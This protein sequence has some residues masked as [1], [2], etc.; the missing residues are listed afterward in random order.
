MKQTF[1][2]CQKLRELFIVMAPIFVSQL[3]VSSTG[4]FNTVMAGHVS[5]QDLAGVATGANLFFMFFIAIMGVIS[6]LTPTISQL[7]GAG[8]REKIPHIVKQAFYW[9]IAISAIFIAAGWLIV[10]FLPD[11]L[12]L[13][14]KVGYVM[15]RYLIAISCGVVQVF[16]AAVLR[17]LI[18]AHGL[19]RLTM[20]ITLITVP[21]NI[22]LNYLFMYGA[23]GFPRLGG[24]G[25][26]VGAAI[27]WTLSLI[28]N[29]FVVTHIDETKHYHVFENFP[30]PDFREWKKQLSLGIPIGATMFCETSIFGVVGLLMTAYGTTIMAAHQAAFNYASV[31]YIIPLSVSMG[32]TII[33][34]YEIGARRP[35]DAWQYS[36]IGRV[37]SIAFAAL[38]GIVLT[39]NRDAITA[40]YTDSETVKDYLMVFLVYA[41]C[42]QGADC[43]NAPLQGTLRGAKDVHVTFLLAVLSD[44][45]IG[46]P[47]GL[48]LAHLTSF[49]QYGY[50]VGLIVGL[51]VGAISLML[52]LRIVERKFKEM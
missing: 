2:Y 34:G 7:Y 16:L 25:A 32:L 11:F 28:I 36:K 27:T 15:T 24:I 52:R 30:R 5:E 4:F 1:S 23:L 45:I 37:L 10:P 47:A 35:E 12:S 29:A 43:I 38:V 18:D 22:F 20:C 13:E 51:L 33:V 6:G 31:V 14:P 50:W 8:K 39:M 46:L 49:A 40:I 9:S 41:T 44:W 48:A 42:V 3:A 21:I 19:T 26:G 17:N